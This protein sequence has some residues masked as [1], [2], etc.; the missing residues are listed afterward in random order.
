MTK[1]QLR[2]ISDWFDS[3]VATFCGETPAKQRNYELKIVHTGCREVVEVVRAFVLA[4]L[5][6]S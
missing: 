6:E 4:R 2:K 3:F 1:E 5:A